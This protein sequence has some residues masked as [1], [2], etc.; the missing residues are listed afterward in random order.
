MI[1]G[2]HPRVVHS[3]GGQPDMWRLKDRAGARNHP[4]GLSRRNAEK[5][6]WL[7]YVRAVITHGLRVILMRATQTQFRLRSYTSAP[8]R[9][10]KRG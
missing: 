1:A 4:N 5:Q 3:S 2:V 8:S 10:V 9:S 6:K 7:C